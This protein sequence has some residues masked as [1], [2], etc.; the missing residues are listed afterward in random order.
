MLG[1]RQHLPSQIN[2]HCRCYSV[3]DFR[4]HDLIING[5]HRTRSF[6]GWIS[7]IT[8]VAVLAGFALCISGSTAWG[9]APQASAT[10][11]HSSAG[12]HQNDGPWWKHALIYEIYPRSFQDSNGDGIGDLNGIT[13]RLDYLKSLGVDAI[14]IAPLYPSPQIDFGYDIS[15]YEN[16][17]PQYGTLA[18]FDKLVAEAK[19]RDIRI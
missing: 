17:D 19:K 4:R 12:A 18:D 6:A 11:T 1:P 5:R 15:D 13:Q 9:Q 16:V 7:F 14:W 3:A 10:A 2:R 8:T